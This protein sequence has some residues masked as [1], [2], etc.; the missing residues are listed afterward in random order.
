MSTP[1]DDTHA[2]IPVKDKGVFFGLAQFRRVTDGSVKLRPVWS[3]IGLALIILVTGLWF[4]KTVAIY[5]LYKF[6][7]NYDQIGVVD[8]FA[9]PLN[10]ASL[11]HKFGEYNIKEGLEEYK[12]GDYRMALMY[13]SAGLARAPENRDARIALSGMYRMMKS[14]ATATNMIIRGLDFHADDALYLQYALQALLSYRMDEEILDFAKKK[15]TASPDKPSTEQ[16]IVAYVAA[17]V[18]SSRGNFDEALAYMDSYK[19]NETA[20]G[21]ILKGRILWT[22]GKKDEAVKL[23]HEFSLRHPG[24]PSAEVH[25]ALCGYLHKLGLHNDA[26]ISSLSVVNNYPDNFMARRDLI[27]AFD[28]TGNH[29]KARSAAKGYM[30]SF[31]KDSKAML[32]LMDYS[33]EAKDTELANEVYYKAAEQGH[34]MG[35][36]GLMMIETYV[37]NGEYAKAEAFCQQLLD[38]NPKWLPMF[39]TQIS[40]LRAVCARGLGQDAMVELH[41]ARVLESPLKGQELYSMARKMDALGM[42]DDALRLLELA[43]QRE[44]QNEEVLALQ[45]EIFLKKGND[46]NFIDTMDKLLDLRRPSY[47]TLAKARERMTSDR[48]VFD[49]RRDD[50]LA[51]LDKAL[52][53]P[54]Q[55]LTKL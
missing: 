33:I 5:S 47:E 43:A 4:A 52:E 13:L 9:F 42:S 37:S 54:N 40:Y 32:R 28:K 35:A 18:L 2:S 1:N 6:V 7:K 8:S 14:E 24:L 22:C 21:T 46:S 38:E 29:D 10:R 3:R 11:T 49:A 31:G 44:P 16:R 50:V 30:R 23:M 15:L 27:E 51:R 26:L 20:E 45:I 53:E 34:N 39:E 55:V 12:N 41:M 36:F 17:Q 25:K 19:I 48:F